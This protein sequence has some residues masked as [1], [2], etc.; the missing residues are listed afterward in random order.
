MLDVF[1]LDLE[2]VVCTFLASRKRVRYARKTLGFAQ[3]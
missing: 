2:E 3:L 1:V